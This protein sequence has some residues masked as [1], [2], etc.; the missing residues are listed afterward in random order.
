[1]AEKLD[2][3]RDITKLIYGDYA[4]YED[5][6]KVAKSLGKII[7]DA[8]Q[9]LADLVALNKAE[10]AN[11]LRQAI[12]ALE[13]K[14]AQLRALVNASE[15]KLAATVKGAADQ[16]R[17]EI[18]RVE[19]SIP[20]MPDLSPLEA[21]IRAVEAKIPVLPIGEDYRNALEALQ[22]DDRL[23]MEAIS[24]L[25]EVL[26]KLEKNVAAAQTR[27][28]AG[29]SVNAIQYADLSSQCDG[30]T[31]TFEVPRHRF[32]ISLSSTSFPGVYRPITDF[33]TA[34]RTLTLTDQ[35]PAPDA[36]QTLIFVYVK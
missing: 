17:E 9:E 35:V 13:E 19:A 15:R 2:K 26:D 27:V 20:A 36:G 3:L 8:K 11:E 6:A 4:S 21:E 18:S 24:G 28:V 25:S 30:V 10:L 12:D 14:E 22:G 34:N 23:K 1:M 31:K 29:P 32:Y 7:T 16:L 33:T 5:V